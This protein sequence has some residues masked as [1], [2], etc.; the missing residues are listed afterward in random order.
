MC[1]WL[2]Y[3]TKGK[4]PVYSSA[5]WPLHCHTRPRP[6]SRTPTAPCPSPSGCLH[7]PRSLQLCSSN[8][9]FPQPGMFFHCSSFCP[10]SGLPA[11]LKWVLQPSPVLPV[12]TLCL[13]SFRALPL[14]ITVILSSYLFVTHPTR[15]WTAWEGWS[16]A[17]LVL[18][19]WHKVSA[20]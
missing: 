2:P 7:T 5:A 8:L 1:W 18:W 15:T 17:R 9:P 16:F 6:A 10:L 20:R 3:G 14:S 13:I 19:A 4:R 12:P 11:H